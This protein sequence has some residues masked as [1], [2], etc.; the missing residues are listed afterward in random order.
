M[1]LF[2]CQMEAVDKAPSTVVSVPLSY[3]P[4]DVS[5][6][7]VR[8]RLVPVFGRDLGNAGL[9]NQ[10]EFCKAM[11]KVSTSWI[12]REVLYYQTSLSQHVATAFV[13]S[14]DGKFRGARAAPQKPVD[15]TDEP[16]WS[17][18]EDPLLAPS[19][20]SAKNPREA[21]LEEPGASEKHVELQPKGKVLSD[22]GSLE[23]SDFSDCEEDGWAAAE[24]DGQGHV[25]EAAS[26]SGEESEKE[27]P[28][29]PR[30]LVDVGK[31]QGGQAGKDRAARTDATDFDLVN[32]ALQPRHVQQSHIGPTPTF[33]V[34]IN[35]TLARV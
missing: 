17:M 20:S 4:Q 13:E 19:F 32:K 33:Q 22:A 6:F 24:H 3:K 1:R 7:P 16:D 2:F 34:T 35:L 31:F 25:Q 8:L 10:F 12:V 28:M 30:D 11:I 21:T 15:A 9:W 14:P 29:K 5:S 18:F 23:G 26:V 27:V